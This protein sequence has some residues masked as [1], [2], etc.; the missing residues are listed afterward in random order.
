MGMADSPGP[1]VREEDAAG[2]A[3]AS[4]RTMGS[5]EAPRVVPSVDRSCQRYRNVADMWAGERLAAGRG[6]KCVRGPGRRGWARAT[7][8]E[9]TSVG[10]D[11]ERVG[12]SALDG[13]TL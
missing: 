3:W 6:R 11:R 1:G 5:G 7:G 13:L 4:G 12:S 10:R 9:G 8:M 2:S